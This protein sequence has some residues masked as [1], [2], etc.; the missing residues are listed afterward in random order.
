M[1]LV[2]EHLVCKD[3]TTIS[4][5]A[6]EFHYC[7]PRNNEGPWTEFETGTVLREGDEGVSGYVSEAE[8]WAYINAHGGLD[9]SALLR[10]HQ[11]VY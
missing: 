4:V 1:L 6:S 3:G 9:L 10:D 2:R 7:T 5:Q 11:L 8:I